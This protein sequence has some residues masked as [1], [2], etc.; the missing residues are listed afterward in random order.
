LVRI[1]SSGLAGVDEIVSGYAIDHELASVARVEG[2]VFE[3]FNEP[4]DLHAFG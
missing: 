2:Q 1:G 4:A 3:D